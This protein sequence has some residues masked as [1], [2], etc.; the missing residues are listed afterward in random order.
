MTTIN[1]PAIRPATVTIVQWLAYIQGALSIL[2]GI[3]FFIYRNDAYIGPVYT[4]SEATIAGV[5]AIAIGLITWWVATSY[6][7]GSRLAMYLIGAVA[8]LNLGS[9]IGYLF[10]HPAHIIAGIVSIV[11]SAFIFYWAISL[12]DPRLLRALRPLKRWARSPVIVSSRSRASPKGA[13]T[14]SISPSRSVIADSR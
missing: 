3:F 13:I 5:I 11:I 9:S 1:T 2:A 10:L 8:L 7:G 4:S 14:R 12:P 6:A